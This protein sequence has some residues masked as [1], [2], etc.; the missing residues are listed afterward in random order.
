VGEEEV[1]FVLIQPNTT[2]NTGN[3]RNER[4][5]VELQRL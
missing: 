2:L 3:V 1:P 5:R 4:T